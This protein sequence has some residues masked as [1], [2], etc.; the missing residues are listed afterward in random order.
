MIIG[1]GFKRPEHGTPTPRICAAGSHR[2]IGK[3][4][5]KTCRR[6]IPELARLGLTYPLSCKK[7]GIH[8]VIG[9]TCIEC[10]EKVAQ[11]A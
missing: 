2:F 6:T 5:C 9:S 3:G 11:P 8:V 4:V 1:P 10:G 7:T